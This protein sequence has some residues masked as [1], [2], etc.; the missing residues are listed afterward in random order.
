MAT[1]GNILCASSNFEHASNLL[2]EMSTLGIYFSI[3][4]PGF[5]IDNDE[6]AVFVQIFRFKGVLK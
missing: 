4:F 5:I 3:Y 1:F 2:T 6:F